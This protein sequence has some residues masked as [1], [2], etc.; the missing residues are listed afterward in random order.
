MATCNAKLQTMEN[1]AD[2]L[3]NRLRRHNLRLVVLPEKVEGSDPVDLLESRLIQGFC[4]DCFSTCFVIERAHRVPGRP[5]P[6]VTPL[7]HW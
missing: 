1:K 2:D 6:R 3:E 7:T 4:R 5:L